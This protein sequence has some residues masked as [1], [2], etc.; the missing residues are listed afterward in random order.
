MSNECEAF[1]QDAI[2]SEVA[3]VSCACDPVLFFDIL[4]DNIAL[5]KFSAAVRSTSASP[6]Y[7]D[8]VMDFWDSPKD[9]DCESLGSCN[10]FMDAFASATHAENQ[11]GVDAKLLQKILQIDSET[12][13]CTIK[14]T[15]ELN[16]QDVNSK[17]S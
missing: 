9:L 7:P 11:K 12:A 17:L 14:T 13:N 8:S 1:K 2:R 3:S 4:D 10:K 5:S 16:R 6:K 15:T